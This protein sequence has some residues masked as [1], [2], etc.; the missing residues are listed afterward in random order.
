MA[1]PEEILSFLETLVNAYPGQ[2]LS[3]ETLKIYIHHLS[4]IHPELL[5]RTAYNL[6]SKSTWFPRVSEIRAE[7]KLIA[8]PVELS[9]Y[10]PSPYRPL[11][12]VFYDLERDFFH[13][14]ILDHSAWLALA[15]EFDRQDRH[16]S[17]KATRNRLAL[18]QHILGVE[19]PAEVEDQ[20]A[21]TPA[22]PSPV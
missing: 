10:D 16:Y 22:L 21:I 7:A 20:P 8:G 14:R 18:F 17:A 2:D 1:S 4:D 13:N 9:T 19:Q 3:R 11:M 12:S 5:R 15:K 6:I